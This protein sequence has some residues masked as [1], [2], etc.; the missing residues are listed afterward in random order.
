MGMPSSSLRHRFGYR[1]RELRLATGMTQEAFADRCGFART[2]MSRIETGG[3][4]PS[5]AAIK[6]VADALK[7]DL[8]SLFADI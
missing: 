1:V 2:Y 5:L 6:T 4:N 8:S 3:A 7:V